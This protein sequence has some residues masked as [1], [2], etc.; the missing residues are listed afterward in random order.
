MKRIGLVSFVIIL[1]LS[2]FFGCKEKGTEAKPTGIELRFRGC[3]TFGA[4]VFIDGEVQGTYT[5]EQPSEIEIAAGPHSLYVRSNLYVSGDTFFCW[6]QD[7]D[8]QQ[9]K[10]LPV[11]LSC[12]GN[13]CTPQGGGGQ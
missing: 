7:I 8:V 11:T 4:Y 12:P 9:D 2:A 10:M 3:I 5:T 1:A 6:T 13:K